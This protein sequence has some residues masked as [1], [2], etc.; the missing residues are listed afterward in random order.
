MEFNL[1]NNRLKRICKKIDIPSPLMEL[2]S[3]IF[4]NKEWIRLVEKNLIRSS[5][6]CEKQFILM[7]GV[8]RNTLENKK[9]SGV[10]KNN[11]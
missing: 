3:I 5:Q 9:R 6:K 7:D 2:K 4:E 8:E 1:S 11:P 10:G